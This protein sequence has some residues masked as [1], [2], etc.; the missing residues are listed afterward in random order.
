MTRGKHTPGPCTSYG[1]AIA[2]EKGGPAI[3]YM[4]ELPQYAGDT[5]K[6]C[7]NHANNAELIVAAFNA[8]TECE[9]LGYDGIEAVKALPELL[10]L[11]CSIENDDAKLPKWLWDKVSAIKSRAR[12]EKEAG[13]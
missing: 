9:S 2:P 3:C 11:I 1:A 10:D 6:P 13:E 5:G 12:G 7:D 4:G 8:A